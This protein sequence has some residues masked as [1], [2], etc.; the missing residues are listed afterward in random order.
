M[1]SN[2]PADGRFSFAN[3]VLSSRSTNKRGYDIDSVATKRA[4][5][6]MKE[7]FEDVNRQL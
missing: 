2:H 1:Y 6:Q 5:S 3:S 4:T 7:H